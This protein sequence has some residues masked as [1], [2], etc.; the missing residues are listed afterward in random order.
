VDILI[1]KRDMDMVVGKFQFFFQV[2]I[3]FGFLV[4]MGSR[5]NGSTVQDFIF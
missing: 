5:S 1:I 2:Y 3:V 4:V